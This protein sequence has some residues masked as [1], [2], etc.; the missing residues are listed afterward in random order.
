MLNQIYHAAR[1]AALR[2]RT[3]V[4]EPFD[5]SGYHSACA[6]RTRLFG[7]VH[8]R[9]GQ[10]PSAQRSRSFLQH[11]QFG[12]RSRVGA[13]FLFI[14]CFEHQVAA[15]EHCTDRHVAG[16]FG[17]RRELQR[18]ANVAFVVGSVL[19]VNE[20]NGALEGIRTPD[21]YLRRVVLYPAEL[22][23]HESALALG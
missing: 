12:V 22:R 15:Y 4:H 11:K 5:A 1:C 18:A 14:L 17:L 13:V 19:H 20:K 2:I 9:V 21:P 23:A 8:S 16:S 7:N 3:T 10:S 6:H